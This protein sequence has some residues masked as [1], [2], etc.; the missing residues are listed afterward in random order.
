MSSAMVAEAYWTFMGI[1]RR[2]VRVVAPSFLILTSFLCKT[3]QLETNPVRTAQF[4]AGRPVTFWNL[5]SIM[6]FM[7]YTWSS[8]RTSPALP[9]KE[10][11]RC[12]SNGR[13]CSTGRVLA[14]RRDSHAGRVCK[15][16]YIWNR[17]KLKSGWTWE[18][19]VRD[20]TRRELGSCIGRSV[21]VIDNSLYWRDISGNAHL[22][23]ACTTHL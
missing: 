1:E 16:L 13:R 11:S 17:S 20:R 21:T 23:S 9:W 4:Y 5:Y 7:I 15:N 2:P 10:S 22:L 14:P 8:L 6:S 3:I 12:S 18:I 19:V